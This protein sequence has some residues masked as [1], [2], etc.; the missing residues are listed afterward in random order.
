MS[1]LD[2]GD[3]QENRIF[4]ALLR[5]EAVRLEIEQ[6]RLK[7]EMPWNT[8]GLVA[9]LVFLGSVICVGLRMAGILK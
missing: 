9:A 8:A 7:A 6:K 5:A 1:N 3:E 4:R 2:G